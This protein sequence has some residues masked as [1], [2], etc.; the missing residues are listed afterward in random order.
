MNFKTLSKFKPLLI[1][2]SMDAI[3]KLFG[4]SRWVDD[5]KSVLISFSL[6]NAFLRMPR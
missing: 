6:E 3:V 2:D 4:R 5:L 1:S